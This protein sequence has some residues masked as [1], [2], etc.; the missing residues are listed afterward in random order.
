[1]SQKLSSWKFK[2][3][4]RS[5]RLKLKMSRFFRGDNIAMIG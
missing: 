2:L 5:P 1:M 4:P 3:M